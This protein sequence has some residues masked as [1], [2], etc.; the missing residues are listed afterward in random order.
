MNHVIRMA[1]IFQIEK[2]EEDVEIT[3]LF[4]KWSKKEFDESEDE[5][6]LIDSDFVYESKTE[7][8]SEMEAES[9]NEENDGIPDFE[10]ASFG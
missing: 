8:E 2:D 1:D 5:S 3:Q 10:I 7:T 6:Y 4:S 9:E